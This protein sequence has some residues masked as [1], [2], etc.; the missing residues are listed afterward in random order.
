MIR[1]IEK[2]V[3]HLWNFD[4]DLGCWLCLKCGAKKDL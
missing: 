4:K 2:C 3:R 1:F